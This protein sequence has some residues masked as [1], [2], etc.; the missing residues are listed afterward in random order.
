MTVRSHSWIGTSLL[1]KLLGRQPKCEVAREF[2]EFI[3]ERGFAEGPDPLWG[4]AHREPF[5]IR[6]IRLK[7]ALDEIVTSNDSTYITISSHSGTIRSILHIIGHREF[8]L[9]TGG[10]IPVVVKVEFTGS[11]T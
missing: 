2:P 1:K 11:A 5:E 10:M 9:D 3:F 7:A 4:P 6:N 8:N